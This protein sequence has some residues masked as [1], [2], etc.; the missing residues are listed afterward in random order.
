[1]ETLPERRIDEL[2]AE[3][4]Q[5]RER[6]E[7]IY[8]KLRHARDTTLPSIGRT[9]DSALVVAGYLET[10]YTALETFFVRVSGYFENDLPQGRWHTTL[11]EKMRSRGYGQKWWGTAI[12]SASVN[13][14]VS[15]TSA[16]TTWRWSTTGLAW[17]SCLRLSTMPIRRC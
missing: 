8:S 14:S 13:C 2:I 15:V 12:S 3:L 11:L 5:A 17:T 7:T 6:V 1:M 16:A 4:A 9:D 10:Y